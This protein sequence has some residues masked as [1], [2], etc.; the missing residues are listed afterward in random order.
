MNY[1]NLGIRGNREYTGADQTI[2]PHVFSNVVKCNNCGFVYLNP[3]IHSEYSSE[4]Q[5]YDNPDTYISSNKDIVRKMFSKRIE[6]ISKFSRGDKLLDIGSGKGEFLD[7]AKYYGYDCLGIEPSNNLNIYSRINYNVKVLTSA[8]LDI[9]LNNY[10]DVITLN[11][12]LEHISKPKLFII[13]I[14][15]LLKD[16]GCLFIEVPNTNS[17]LLKINDLYFR[18]KGLKWSSRLSP[19][20][21][22][23]HRYG[24]N[25][26]SLSY[27]LSENGFEIKRIKLFPGLDR[28]YIKAKNSSNIEHYLRHI[29]SRFLSIF[30]N[31]ELLAIIAYKM[32]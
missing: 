10:Y 26:K 1:K 24:Y 3:P 19:M 13:K 7:V 4:K 9:E 30:G 25:K 8:F 32:K 2:T 27:L 18:L 21:P 14:K 6:L 11:H 15:Q 31:R 17:N 23:F 29:S 5:H 16:D 20:H 28:G 12:V 22:P